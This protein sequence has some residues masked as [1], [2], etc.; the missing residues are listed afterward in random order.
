MY[1]GKEYRGNGYMANLI[2]DITNIILNNNLIPVLQTDIN[3]KS[4]NKSYQNVGYKLEDV[5]VKANYERKI[6]KT[7]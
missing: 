5:L 2:Y 7:L 4:S 1:T 3:Y 6:I